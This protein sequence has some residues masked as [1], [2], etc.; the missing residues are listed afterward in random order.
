MSQEISQSTLQFV[1]NRIESI[2]EEY[3]QYPYQVAFSMQELRKKLL[4]QVLKNLPHRHSFTDKKQASDSTLKPI[5]HSLEDRVRIETL[6]RGSIYHVLRE[7]ADWVSRH[8]PQDVSLENSPKNKN[9][10]NPYS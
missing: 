1:I 4:A 3:P 9:G 10:I 2:L 6:I 8:L 7:N 5:N